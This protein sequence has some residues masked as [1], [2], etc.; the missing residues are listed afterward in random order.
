MAGGV[1]NTQMIKLSKEIW[2][3]LLSRGIT[4]TT[5]Y[6]PSK[7]NVI[8]DRESR[9]RADSSEW[10]LCA[11]EVDLF[12]SR[13]THQLPHYV[14]WR[15]D[16][17]SQATDAMQ[18]DWSQKFLYAFPPFCLINRVLQKVRHEESQCILIIT[19]T[20]HT[21]PWYPVLLQMIIEAP[22]LLPR[23]NILLKNPS[24]SVHPLIGN[25][26]LRL[27]AW[28]ISGKKLSWSGISES[29]S[30]LIANP[31]RESSSG[32]YESAWRKWVGWCH[33]RH[34][35]PISCDLIP[36]LDFLGEM[37]D[38]GYEYRTIN[39]HRSAI[40][41]FHNNIDGVKFESHKQVCQLLS[42]VFNRRP[43]QPKYTF[44]WDVQT[45]LDYIK[46]V[47]PENEA[48]SDKHL[49]L[50]LTMPLA[51][52]STSRAIQIHHLDI[53]Q[54]GGLP[55]QYRFCYT[56]LHKGW[57][58]P[59][60]DFYAYEEDPRLCVVKCLDEYFSRSKA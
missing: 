21:Q 49:T 58:K 45:V 24:G 35:D 1:K 18:Q 42:G 15:Q 25:K 53:S 34:V 38:A 32:S 19:P 28:K 6:L 55:D 12:A 26:T 43:P 59:S 40:S 52:T 9:E 4:V 47:W 44:I 51:L 20:W 46:R 50:K 31:R 60:V 37:F 8:A 16:P 11:E 36:I 14:A 41:A 7:M 23:K 30:K 10:K 29:A 2:N 54:M 39:S 57:E 56:K 33:R 17:Y 22:I 48:L 13:L 5:E 3:Y 27:A